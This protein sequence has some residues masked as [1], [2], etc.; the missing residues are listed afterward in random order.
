[1]GVFE[2]ILVILEALCSLALIVV[3]LLQSGKEAGL[4]GALSGASD[5]YLNKNKKGGLDQV[6]ASSTK[7]LAIVWVVLTLILSLV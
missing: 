3:V 5:S 4:S 7:W 2:T 1:M 6:L